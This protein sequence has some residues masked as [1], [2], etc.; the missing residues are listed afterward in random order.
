MDEDEVNNRKHRLGGHDEAMSSKQNE[1]ID[2]TETYW[3]KMKR[4]EHLIRPIAPLQPAAG[5]K[6]PDVKTADAE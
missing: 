1:Y 3:K 5:L 2:V 4:A 6:K